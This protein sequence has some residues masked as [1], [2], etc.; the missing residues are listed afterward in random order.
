[1]KTA[2]H[3]F[4]KDKNEFFPDSHEN[5]Y[6]SL[7]TGPLLTV[8]NNGS[9]LIRA[10]DHVHEGRYTCQANNGIGGGLSKTVFLRVNGTVSFFLLFGT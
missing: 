6:V 1:M 2:Y 5:D 10:A 7:E 8:S 4:K 9:V 3:R